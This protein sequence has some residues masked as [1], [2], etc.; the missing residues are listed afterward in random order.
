MRQAYY[1]TEE[2]AM[3]FSVQKKIS[4]VGIWCHMKWI[5]GV[6]P[7]G[8][9]ISIDEVKKLNIS[10]SNEIYIEDI[11]PFWYFREHPNMIYDGHNETFAVHDDSSSFMA[12][13]I[14]SCS[15]KI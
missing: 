6:T 9:T 7:H 8:V 5:T 12:V 3:H 14:I 15:E 1:S 13:I 2:F 11:K 10:T 4:F